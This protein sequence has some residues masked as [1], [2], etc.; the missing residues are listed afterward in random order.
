MTNSS[1][2]SQSASTVPVNLLNRSADLSGFKFESTAE[3]EAIDGLLG[4]ERALEA[5]RFGTQIE[6]PGFNLF[7]IGQPDARMRQTVESLLR[8][9]A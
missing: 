5:I 6:K 2:N 1:V 4:Q 9:A 3:L 7:V 8:K